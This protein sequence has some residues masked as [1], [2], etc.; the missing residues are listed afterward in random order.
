MEAH[1]HKYWP[2]AWMLARANELYAEYGGNMSQLSDE[3]TYSDL[4]QM[5][6]RMEI[7]RGLY[8]RLEFGW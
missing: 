1:G 8:R 4:Q 5:V 6:G 7:I 3:Y 2:A